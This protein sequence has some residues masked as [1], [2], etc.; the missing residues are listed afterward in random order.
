MNYKL[1]TSKGL[2]IDGQP[3]P[4]GVPLGTLT[5]VEGSILEDEH[6]LRGLQNGAVKVEPIEPEPEA[7]AVETPA[8]TPDVADT[9]QAEPVETAADASITD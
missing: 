6:V 4:A 2:V 9:D 5:T 7:V 8:E 1:I 3:V